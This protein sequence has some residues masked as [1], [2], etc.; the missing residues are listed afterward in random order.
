MHDELLQSFKN[1]PQNIENQLRSY[2]HSQSFSAGETVFLQGADPTAVYL[3]ASGR[4]KVV[5]VTPEG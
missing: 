2:L 5:R 4:V 3:V 1:L